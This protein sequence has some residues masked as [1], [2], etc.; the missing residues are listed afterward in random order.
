M[1]R[2]QKIGALPLR[3]AAQVCPSRSGIGFEKLYRKV[4]EPEKA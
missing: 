1:E 3:S 2:M 4:F